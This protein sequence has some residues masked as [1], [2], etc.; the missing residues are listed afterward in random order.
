M[1]NEY[2]RH[3]LIAEVILKT[4]VSTIICGM[5][6]IGVWERLNVLISLGVLLITVFG[7]TR[8]A[9]LSEADNHYRQKVGPALD[10][11]RRL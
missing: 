10:R 11:G 4:S 6:Q 3:R 9:Q 1:T 8:H 7:V 2:T 5:I